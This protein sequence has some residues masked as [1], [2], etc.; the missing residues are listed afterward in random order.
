[1]GREMSGVIFTLHDIRRTF[2]TIAEARD[3]PVYALKRLVNHST[4]NSD[5]T[6]GHII[7]DVE[8]L[9]KPMQKITDFILTT[10]G[11]KPTATIVELKLAKT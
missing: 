9:R 11:I 3:I 1:M 8:R 6:D 10:A 2:I 5:V 7:T 4:K